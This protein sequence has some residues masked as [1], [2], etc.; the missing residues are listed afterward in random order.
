MGGIITYLMEAERDKLCEIRLSLCF[1]RSFLVKIRTRLLSLCE[2]PAML[3]LLQVIMQSK[4][5]ECFKQVVPT[6]NVKHP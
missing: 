6:V 3:Y 5:L 4:C 1:C 2:V